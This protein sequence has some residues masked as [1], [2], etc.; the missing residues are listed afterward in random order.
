MEL[1]LTTRKA[2][3]I[4]LHVMF[5]VSYIYYLG[6]IYDW[7]NT[8]ELN[9][10]IQFH[11]GGISIIVTILL[12]YFN[13]YVLLPLFYVSKRFISYAV[14]LTLT[15]LAGAILI[16]FLT[17][18]FILPWEKIHDP[19]RYAKEVKHF[20]IPG[21]ILRVAIE[22]YPVIAMVTVF[23]LIRSAYRNEKKLRELEQE[24]AA[25]EINF[26]KAQI[27]PHFFFN[28]LNSL[29]ALINK[30]SDKAGPLV[31]QLSDLMRYMLQ[32][33]TADRVQLTDEIRHLENYLSIEQLRF[34][35]RLDLSFSVTGNANGILVMPLLLLPFAENAFKHG[36][37]EGQGWITIDLKINEGEIYYRIENSKA[38]KGNVTAS[39]I[40]LNNFS[41]RLELTYPNRFKFNAHNTGETFEA[42]LKVNV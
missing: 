8:D 29:Y 36:I 22:S 10:N 11:V 35:D 41:R 16:R 30:R 27:H 6:I 21:R 18:Q 13:I 32:K 17:N 37:E 42:L 26:L 31:L 3:I 28:T 39:G 24:K 9:F 34:A 12:T 23:D 19:V 1:K 38:K 2:G 20:W 5:W 40:G 25:A 14:A 15:L 33:V 7:Q 4:A